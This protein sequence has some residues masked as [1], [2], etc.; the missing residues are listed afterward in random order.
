MFEQVLEVQERTLGPDHPTVAATLSN[1]ATALTNLERHDEAIPLQE[2]SAAID[3]Q[4]FGDEDDRT[5]ES[6]R[7]LAESY[8]RRQRGVMR[9]SGEPQDQAL[10]L[11]ATMQGAIQLAR[12]K[13]ADTLQRIANQVT[14][15][16]KPRD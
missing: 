11:M 15:A 13:G 5:L 4:H 7:R 6:L 10:T 12:A 1:L 9:F 8:Q 3:R 2:R 14:S 16:L